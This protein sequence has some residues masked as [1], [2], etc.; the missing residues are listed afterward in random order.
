MCIFLIFFILLKICKN[1]VTD[2]P[3]VQTWI[4]STYWNLATTRTQKP[5]Y[6]ELKPER[7]EGKFPRKNFLWC[8]N[9]WKQQER[10]MRWRWELPLSG[11]PEQIFRGNHWVERWWSAAEWQ[12]LP[13]WPG[14]DGDMEDQDGQWMTI[15]IWERKRRN[16]WFNFFL[17][18]NE[19]KIY[20]LHAFLIF[21]FIYYSQRDLVRIPKCVKFLPSRIY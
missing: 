16:R 21:K 5:L 6:K 14:V 2:C 17:M 3:N 9:K 19:K 1:F 20:H 12:G 11:F 7:R 13:S 18:K 10:R 4:W 15:T 8:G